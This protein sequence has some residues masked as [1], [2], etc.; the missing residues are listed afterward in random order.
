MPKPS[1]VRGIKVLV[2]RGKEL[3]NIK[4]KIKQ[5]AEAT[6]DPFISGNK[7]KARVDG[8]NYP[9]I[10]PLAAWYKSGKNIKRFLKMVKIPVEALTRELGGEAKVIINYR[11]NEFNSVTFLKDGEDFD[12]TARP[13]RKIDI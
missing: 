8:K 9:S 11:F 5:H 6:G 10:D 13:L 12:K 1:K 3:S 2:D 4:A 7:H